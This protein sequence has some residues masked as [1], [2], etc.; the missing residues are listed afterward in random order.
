MMSF[1]SCKGPCVWLP[2][3]PQKCEFKK[4]TSYRFLLCLPAFVDMKHLSK[5][6]LKFMS[7]S[8]HHRL[9]ILKLVTSVARLLHVRESRYSGYFALFHRDSFWREESSVKLKFNKAIKGKGWRYEGR[10]FWAFTFNLM[11]L[12]ATKG[13]LRQFYE[14]S[15]ESTLQTCRA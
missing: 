9:F 4:F 14:N 15:L 13:N 10:V 2:T 8:Y 1:R 5:E 12:K 6:L 7:H 3:Y 11:E